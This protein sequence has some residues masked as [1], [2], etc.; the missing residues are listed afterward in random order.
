MTHHDKKDE[1]KKYAPQYKHI[2]VEKKQNFN[3]KIPRRFVVRPYSP[4]TLYNLHVVYIYEMTK[5]LLKFTW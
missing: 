1:T 4:F 3:I 2:S 5:F